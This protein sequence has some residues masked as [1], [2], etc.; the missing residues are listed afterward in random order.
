MTMCTS[1]TVEDLWGFGPDGWRQDY[2]DFSN[3][4]H[5]TISVEETQKYIKALQNDRV[6][7]SAQPR[8]KNLST[9]M[10]FKLFTSVVLASLAAAVLAAPAPVP[11]PVSAPAE[12]NTAKVDY[13]FGAS[14]WK[15]VHH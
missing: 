10:Q 9:T 7:S 8:L 12:D 11:V 6:N 5:A 3:H 15:P 14:A 13:F 4:C 2:G 1:P